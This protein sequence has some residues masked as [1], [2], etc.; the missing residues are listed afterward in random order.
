MKLINLI[1]LREADADTSTPEL[2]ALPF[3]REFQTKHGYKPLFK[4]LGTKNE[5][6]VFTADVEDLGALELIFTEAQ[7]MAKVTEKEA[8][9]GMIY[10]ST[11][12]EKTDATI[13]KMKMKDGVIEV[14]HFDPKDNKNFDA[15]TCKFLA[16]I[17]QNNE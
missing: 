7:I 2:T 9:F 6:Y 4:Y 3:F 11:G 16:L 15:K 17:T 14:L 5:Q 8:V 13:C 1:P 12:L 10:T